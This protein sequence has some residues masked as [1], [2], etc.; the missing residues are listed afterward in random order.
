MLQV[1]K[2]RRVEVESEGEWWDAE[3]L[4]IKHGQ[5]KIHY[6]GGLDDEDEWIEIGRY[7]PFPALPSLRI[8]TAWP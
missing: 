3:I 6:V 4:K 8:F 1:T 7:R 2:G 5:F